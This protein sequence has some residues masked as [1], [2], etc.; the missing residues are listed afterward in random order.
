M[1]PLL[2]YY[3]IDPNVVRFVGTGAW[4]DEVFYDEPSLSGS[5]Y[6]GIEYNNR[7]QLNDDYKDLFKERLLRTSTLPYDIVGLL[8]YL[9]NN[10]YSI[11]AFYKNV[12]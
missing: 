2:P 5:I 9:I 12:F 8:D 3:D 1:A 11:S 4:D 10:N 6:P 7:Q